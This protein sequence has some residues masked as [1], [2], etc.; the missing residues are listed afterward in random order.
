VA[1]PKEKN[2]RLFL[3]ILLEELRRMEFYFS[4]LFQGLD[5]A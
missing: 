4:G 5:M 3:K 1:I 2:I